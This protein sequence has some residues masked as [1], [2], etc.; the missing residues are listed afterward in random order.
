MRN[1]IKKIALALVSIFFFASL[2]YGYMNQR[3]KDMDN[4]IHIPFSYN[5]WKPSEM[6]YFIDKEAQHCFKSKDPTKILNRSYSSMY[7]EWWLHNIGYY[8]TI[9]AT[10]ENDFFFDLNMRFRDVDLEEWR[11]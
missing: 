1:L 10:D 7:V 6:R 5:I 3:N 9:W 8:A 4:I 2:F 11:T